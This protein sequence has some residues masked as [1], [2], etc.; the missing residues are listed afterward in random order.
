VE[1]RGQKKRDCSHRPETWKHSHKRS[2]QN[3]DEAEKKIHRLKRNPEAKED[4]VK[5]IHSELNDPS[6]NSFR[7]LS[8]EPNLENDIRANRDKERCEKDGFKA[9]G[10]FD[11]E[12]EE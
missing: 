7:E 1:G 8:L 10:A 3:A 12:Q 6:E 11:P 9:I 2:N 5:D 4:V